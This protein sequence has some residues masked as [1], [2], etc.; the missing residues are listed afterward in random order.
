MHK[1]SAA[2][3]D[4]SSQVLSQHNCIDCHLYMLTKVIEYIDVDLINTC[5]YIYIGYL[6]GIQS[7]CFKDI[8]LLEYTFHCLVVC[9]RQYYSLLVQIMS[10]CIHTM[11]VCR[12]YSEWNVACY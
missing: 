12:W 8:M 11:K 7:Q 1:L 5:K 6:L 10:N 3:W 2:S 9:G 4:I